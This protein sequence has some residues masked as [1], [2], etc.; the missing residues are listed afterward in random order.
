VTL[1]ATAIVAFGVAVARTGGERRARE[2]PRRRSRGLGLRREETLA[3][4]LRRMTL[5]Q[6]DV[7]IEQLGEAERGDLQAG[8]HEARKAI[9]RLRTIVRLLEGTLGARPC[10]REQQALRSAAALLAGARDAEVMSQTLDALVARKR[11]QL[12]G[13]PGVLSIRLALARD[14]EQA[15]ERI[16]SGGNLAAAAD[17]L[18]RFRARAAAWTLAEGPSIALVD[19]GLRRVYR[20]GRRRLS[21]AG[22]SHGGRMRTMHQW[23]KRVKDLRYAAEV[24]Q[25]DPPAG[26]RAGGKM[27]RLKRVARRADRLGEVLGEEHDL[28]VL[29]EWVELHGAAAGAGGAT[30]RRLRKAIAKRRRKLRR[31][32]LREGA[33]LY[34][35]KPKRFMRRA[36]QAYAREA[37]PLS[38]R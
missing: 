29:G 22:G 9:K 16:L 23:R 27:R 37:D 3:S 26:G 11:P 5:E 12:D 28:A 10:A 36:A 1:A 32:A 14:R 30:R 33:K 19:R 6:A 34:A 21:R 2:R 18:R 13:R 15:R 25:R 7:V 24:L 4:G 31:R 20:Q 35:R 38:R 17:E 8:V